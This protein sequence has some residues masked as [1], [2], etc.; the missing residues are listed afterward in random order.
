MLPFSDLSSAQDQDYLCEGMGEE[1]MNTLVRI[2]GSAWR[3]ACREVAA[4]R[5]QPE[6]QAPDYS[7][8]VA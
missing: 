6:A 2:E 7:C 5:S 4:C 8:L 1:I 3:R